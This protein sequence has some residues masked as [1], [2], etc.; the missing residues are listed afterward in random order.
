MRIY[1]VDDEELALEMLVEA[2][3]DA[4]PEAVVLSFNTPF[5]CLEQIKE[6]P[7]DVLFSD[8]Q[9]PEASGIDFTGE[10]QK[11]YPSMNIVFVTAYDEYA[12]QA[13]NMYASGYVCK[14]ATPE[15]IKKEMQNLRFP[16]KELGQKCCRI[17][18]Y[19]HFEVFDKQNMPVHFHR[20]KSKEILAY[21]VHNRGAFCTIRQIAAILFEDA[22]YDLKQTRYMQKLISTLLSD[23]EENHM[24]GVVIRSYN[25]LALDVNKVSCDYF[26]NPERR[27]VLL[28]GGEYMSQYS[29]AETMY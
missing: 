15:K 17:Q 16:L 22:P 3:R 26:D 6:E 24:E 21:L 19:G 28:E 18:C 29:W 9:M 14:P 20:S 11:L 2:I 5:E 27:Q 13:M 25:T 7:C 10:C 4:Y 23:L 8:I 1:A 12:L